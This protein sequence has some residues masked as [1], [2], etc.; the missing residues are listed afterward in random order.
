MVVQKITEIFQKRR[1]SDLL[2]SVLTHT[3]TG[4]RIYAKSHFNSMIIEYYV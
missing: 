4:R 3:C 2:A 1:K